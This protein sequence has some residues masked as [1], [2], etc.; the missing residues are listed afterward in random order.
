LIGTGEKVVTNSDEAF[1]L[2]MYKNYISKWKMQGNIEDD[3]DKQ[4]EEDEDEDKQHEEDDEIVQSG[5]RRKKPITKAL[6]GKYTDHNNGTTKYGGWS[7]KGMER[8]NEL[9]KLVK[10]RQEMPTGCGNGKGVSGSC[11]FQ[12]F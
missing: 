10:K 5:P 9:Y 2:L 1:A 7:E 12:L 6:R 11:H 8:F 4:H 3:K